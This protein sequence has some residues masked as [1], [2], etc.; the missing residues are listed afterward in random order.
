MITPSHILYNL[1]LLGKKKEPWVIWAIALGALFPDVPNFIFF[2]IYGIILRLPHEVLWDGMYFNSSWNHVFNLSH[3]FWLVPLLLGISYLYKK[4][5]AVFF[6][7]SMLIHALMDFCVHSEDAYAHFWPFSAWRF[8]SPFSYW[9]PLHYGV[10]VST[11]EVLLAFVAGVVL[12]TRSKGRNWKKVLILIVGV[13][14][15]L[16]FHGL[17]RIYAS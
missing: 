17:Y 1:V 4:R 6:F 10:Y 13:E 14:L 11:L 7:S 15:L 16:V 3:S 12:Y 5:V 9:D 2:F 8:Q